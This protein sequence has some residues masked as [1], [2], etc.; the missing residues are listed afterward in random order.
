M[1][2]IKGVTL[3]EFEKQRLI[4]SREKLLHLIEEISLSQLKIM[5]KMVMIVMI[6]MK[7]I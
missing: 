6:P 1:E 5:H 4:N 2:Q 3:L 7:D